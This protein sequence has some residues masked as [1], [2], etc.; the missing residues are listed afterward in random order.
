MPIA[1]VAMNTPF[2][3]FPEAFSMPV[4]YKKSIS[5][6]TSNVSATA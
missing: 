4:L 6:K 1:A 3:N 5:P 2:T